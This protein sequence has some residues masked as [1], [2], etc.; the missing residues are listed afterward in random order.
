[1]ESEH[2]GLIIPSTPCILQELCQR[3]LATVVD[4][5]LLENL[6]ISLR[7]F[8]CGELRLLE[9]LVRL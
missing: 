7:Y 1:M 9:K 8:S 2:E 6:Q 4:I 5:G 3:H